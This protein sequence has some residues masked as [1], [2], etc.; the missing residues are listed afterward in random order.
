MNKLI[1]LSL[2]L[3]GGCLDAASIEAPENAPGRTL[4]DDFADYW[5]QGEAEITSFRLTQARYGELRSGTAVHVYVTEDFRKDRLVKLNNQ[6]DVDADV[7]AKILK[8]N[9]TTNYN[10]GIYPYSTMTSAFTDLHDP[11]RNAMKVTAT[12]QEWCGHVYSH[13]AQTANG[14]DVEQHSYFEEEADAEFTLG[15]ALTEDGIWNLIRIDP[16]LLPVGDLEII[17]SLIY[18]RYSHSNWK[19]ENA[20]AKLAESENGLRTY[21]LSYPDIGRD[22][23]I[24]FGADFPHEVQGWTGKRYSGFGENRHLLTTSAE[25]MKSIKL[26]YWNRNKNKDEFFREQLGL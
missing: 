21:A 8:L 16:D 25:R 1:F 24:T 12:V 23:T 13:L 18:Q 26:D 7:V 3:L 11:A 20:V 15:N 14:Y 10:T 5:Y 9:A 17:P 2:L 4:P 6:N 22:V 19:V